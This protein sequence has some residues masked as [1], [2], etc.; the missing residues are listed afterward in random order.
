[1][2]NRYLRY[3]HYNLLKNIKTRYSPSSLVC[4]CAAIHRS[5]FA[6]VFAKHID[7][8]VDVIFYIYW[9][10]T[11]LLFY[12]ITGEQFKSSNLLLKYEVKEFVN[13]GDQSRT[14]VPIEEADMDRIRQHFDRTFAQIYKTK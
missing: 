2:L 4:I 3:F 7:I 13:S 6:I 9:E 5:I 1:M 11:S 8:K 12:C 10:I 14:Y